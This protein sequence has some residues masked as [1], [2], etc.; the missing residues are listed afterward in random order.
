VVEFLPN[1]NLMH[2]YLA[3][4]RLCEYL[5]SDGMLPPST[6]IHFTEKPK[7]NFGFEVDLVP[8]NSPA[9]QSQIR[10]RRQP[11]ERVYPSFDKLA[12][13]GV[14]ATTARIGRW[15]LHPRPSL[16]MTFKRQWRRQHQAAFVSFDPPIIDDVLEGTLHS[17]D[18]LGHL[19]ARDL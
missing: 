13:E 4:R 11:P 18:G 5:D 17:L 8:C 12:V 9:R 10:S 2:K 14:S 15:P 3:W 6:A 16:E 19:T 1:L 7:S